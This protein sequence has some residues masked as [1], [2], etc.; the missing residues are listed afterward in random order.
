MEQQKIGKRSEADPKYTWATEDLFVSDDAWLE[1]LDRCGELVGRIS[2]Y[3]GRLG[4][5]AQTLL[6][7]FKLMDE[8]DLKLGRLGSYAHLKA[9]ED[10]AVSKYQDFRGKMMGLM[11]KVSSA[12]AFEEPEILNISEETLEQ[13]MA[14]E[15]GLKEY[16]R[17]LYKIR[18]MKAHV[19]TEAEERI[20]AA[21][22]SVCQSPDLIGSTF[23]NA[24]LKY[25]NVK[26]S[27]GKEYVL[28]AGSYVSLCQSPDRVLRKNAFE[29]L[30]ATFYQYRNTVAAILNAQVKQ[31]IFQAD[32]RKYN[33]T[34]EAA[35][36]RNEVPVSVYHNL[37]K[38]VHDNMGYLHR[39]MSL[40]QKI[41]GVD[42]LHMYD[43]YT[44][45]VTSCDQKI[46]F[47]EAKENVLEGLAVLGED[48][49]DVLREGFSNR[50]I[51]VYEN[52]GKRSGAYSSGAR[53][54]P[55]VLLN[56]KD[57]LGSQFT[58]AHEMGHALH[59]YFSKKT[60][61]VSQSNYVIFVAEVASTCNEV[62]L[63]KHLL[64]K[65]EDRE[66]KAYLLNYFL[67]QFRT[68][69][70]RQAMFAEFEMMMNAK[71]EAGESL[72]ADLLSDMYYK[73]NKEYYGEE[74]AV[75][76][77]IAIEWARIP[78]LFYNFYV[79]QYATGFSA[80]VALANKILTEGESAVKN[81]RRFL[82]LGGSQ[83]PISL[84]KI[85]GVDM[86]TAQPVTEALHLFGEL[87]DE[88]E[89]LMIK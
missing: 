33:S 88:M 76:Q 16:E 51:D 20:M 19:L 50:W 64:A 2:E 12:A 49:L 66:E 87:L 81:Y 44:P 37:L 80:A 58:L 17:S 79:F 83:D 11:V 47:E 40:R 57:T 45:M 85:A 84:L 53:P 46:S 21:A 63:M 71:A 67:E 55:Y 26:D 82:T 61:P 6:G 18:R 43:V 65:T 56:H 5:S 68:T 22:A 74:M 13:F 15:P 31:L 9:D 60:Q 35:L 41:M 86:T 75:D 48:Y 72:T 24:D 34:L 28:T 54:H 69:L 10:S 30:Y 89:Q 1:E 4:E 73:L 25:P 29:T 77:D 14:A 3:K 23:R 27:E 38:A 42:K 36:Y 32:M 8:A 59:S 52:E 39:Y 62:L 70:Y 7:W 78:H